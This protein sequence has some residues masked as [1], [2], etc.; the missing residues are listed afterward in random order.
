MVA[1][2]KARVPSSPPVCTVRKSLKGVPNV[3]YTAET[4]GIPW[5]VDI[6]LGHFYRVQVGNGIGDTFRTVPSVL[7]YLLRSL[8]VVTVPGKTV[9]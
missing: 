4:N 3:R 6:Y 7:G 2:L 5:L 1:T 9:R 8:G